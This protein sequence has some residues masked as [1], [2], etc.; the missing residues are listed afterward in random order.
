[1][2]DKGR[3]VRAEVG[4]PHAIEELTLDEARAL[5]VIAQRLDRRPPGTHNPATVKARLLTTI[6]A[7]GCVQLDTINVV[8]RSHETVLWRRLGHYVPPLLA[9]L[10]YP[11]GTL[12]MYWAHAAA[13]VPIEDFRF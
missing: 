6:R 12:F 9:E 3:I 5:A 7:L 1:M 8:S 10:H 2:R 4:D 11:D 13:L